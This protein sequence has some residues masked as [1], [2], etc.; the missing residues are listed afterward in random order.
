M[1]IRKGSIVKGNYWPEPVEVNLIENM[2]NYVRIVGVTIWG[3]NYI[4]Q[5]IT[6]D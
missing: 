5:I 4:D 2:G 6:Q 1:E 3:K